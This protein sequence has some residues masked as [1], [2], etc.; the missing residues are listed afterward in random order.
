MS[1]Y[2]NKFKELVKSKKYKTTNNHTHRNERKKYH[3]NKDYN[4]IINYYLKHAISHPNDAKIILLMG[5][6]GSGKN[7]LLKDLDLIRTL[8]R[9]S[10]KN[11]VLIDHDDIICL[12]PDY[13]E[14]RLKNN[15]KNKDII[16]DFKNDA[17]ILSQLILDLSLEKKLNIIYNGTGKNLDGY[18]D[19]IN[20][21]KNNNYEIHLFYVQVD[22][23]LSFNRVEERFKKYGR[24][25]PKKII[26]LCHEN[27]PENFKI[28]SKQVDN[29]YLLTSNENP[30]KMV[31]FKYKGD[32]IILD[33]NYYGSIVN[34]Q[35][36]T[37]DTN[38]QNT[39]SIQKSTPIDIPIKNN[40]RYSYSGSSKIHFTPS[41]KEN[42]I[43]LAIGSEDKLYHHSSIPNNKI[44]SPIKRKN[45]NIFDD[46]YILSLDNQVN[47]LSYNIENKLK[48]KYKLP[49]IKQNEINNKSTIIKSENDNFKNIK[50][51]NLTSLHNVTKKNRINI[52]NNSLN[53]SSNNY[54]ISKNLNN[55]TNSLMKRNRS[56]TLDSN[57]E[58][59]NYFNQNILEK[60]KNNKN[61][62]IIPNKN[63]R[64]KS[65]SVC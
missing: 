11:S 25:V 42:K 8:T 2:V 19:L 47:K 38:N 56:K 39:T 7:R 53:T 55:T 3:D 35:N 22:K 45:A 44:I 27:V 60:K 10:L 59:H 33:S 48:N 4:N 37:K 36:I 43:Y 5:C 62:S 58:F 16:A 50:K 34:H 6:P 46:T 54:D 18:Q 64:E 28:L 9:Q 24:N 40:R 20:Q 12:L 51:N 29:C 63:Q 49:P 57:F 21:C 32:E 26:D 15:N 13:W 31:W 41:P 23:Q 52:A 17:Y 30:S 1:T 61:I 14:S 65:K